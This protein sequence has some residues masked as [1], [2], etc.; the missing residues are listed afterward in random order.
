MEEITQ[1]EIKGCRKQVNILSKC[2]D[3]VTILGDRILCKECINQKTIKMGD[4]I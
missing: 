3:V 2:G 4:N 1:E